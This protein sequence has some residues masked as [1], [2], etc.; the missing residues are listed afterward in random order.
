MLEHLVDTPVRGVVYEAAGSADPELLGAGA[1]AVR[2]ASA[3]WSIPAEVVD[4]D[5]ADHDAWLVAMGAAV[6]RLL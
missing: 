4:K 6:S 3:T 2:R 5:P 1:A